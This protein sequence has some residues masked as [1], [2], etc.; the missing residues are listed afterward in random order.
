MEEDRIDELFSR[1]D[2]MQSYMEHLGDRIDFL[3]SM[4]RMQRKSSMPP[5]LVSDR[6][7]KILMSL[8]G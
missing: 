8:D 7:S 6:K 5:A 4:S 2:L 1:L 3:I